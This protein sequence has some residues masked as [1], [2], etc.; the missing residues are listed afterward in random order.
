MCCS[1]C[2]RRAASCLQEVQRRKAAQAESD[3]LKAEVDKLRPQLT[4]TAGKVAELQAANAELRVTLGELRQQLQDEAAGV[5][6]PAGSS[7]AN[8]A[9]IAQLQQQ[10]TQRDAAVA[11]LRQAL[12]DAEQ[13]V[14]TAAASAGVPGNSRGTLGS[15]EA[16]A[17]LSALQQR[18]VMLERE[19]GDLRSELNAFDPAFFDEIEDLKH[20]H[21][22]LQQRCAEQ[23]S[24]ISR[25]QAQLPAA[26]R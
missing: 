7:N 10:L 17:Q 3:R 21:H 22:Q 25:L 24:L 2:F 8:S 14:A 19:N 5:V 4:A 6:R 12:G 11:G 16:A 13:R 1:Q 18:V 23:A 9:T 20:S 26:V 15:S